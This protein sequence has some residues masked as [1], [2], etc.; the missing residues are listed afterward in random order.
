MIM[1]A[2]NKQSD[3]YCGASMMECSYLAHLSTV[4]TLDPCLER[5]RLVLF[6]EHTCKHDMDRL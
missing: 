4:C 3:G 1:A 2:S 5:L 6:Y